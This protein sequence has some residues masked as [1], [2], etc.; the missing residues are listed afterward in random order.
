METI[1]PVIGMAILGLVAGWLTGLAVRK[2]ASLALLAVVV[3]V[4]LQL[5]G[6]K[7]V[8]IHWDALPGSAER[9]AHSVGA[10]AH[11]ASGHLWRLSAYNLPFSIGYLVGVLRGLAQ[12]R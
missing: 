7:L 3:F 4:A 9:A 12:R 6:Y 5:I 8:L 10:T 11:R 1:G 2:A